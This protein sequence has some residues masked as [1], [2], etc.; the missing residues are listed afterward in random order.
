[1]NPDTDIAAASSVELSYDG[2]NIMG[3]DGSRNTIVTYVCN[4]AAEQPISIVNGEPRDK[5]YAFTRVSKDICPKSLR[6]WLLLRQD[7]VKPLA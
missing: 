7:Q 3:N 1:M 5:T 4:P 6:Q 2:S